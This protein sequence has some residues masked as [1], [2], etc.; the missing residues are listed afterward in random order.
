MAGTRI[1]FISVGTRAKVA[2]GNMTPGTPAGARA[3]DVYICINVQRDNVAASMAATWGALYALNNGTTTRAHAW[4][5]RR[6]TS[7]PD[8]TITRAAGNTGIACVLCFRNCWGEES[9]E[10]PISTTQTQVVSPTSDL[11]VC[12]SAT[13]PVGNDP[14]C[15]NMC[16]FIGHCA[17]NGT[18]DFGAD[19]TNPVPLQVLDD[20][21]ALGLDAGLVVSVGIHNDASATGAR[22]IDYSLSALHI[23]GTILLRAKDQSPQMAQFGV[24]L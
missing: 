23:G 13:P 24:G 22:T 16:I 19:G 9:G 20:N 17:D 2:S 8:F 11:I 3:G 21:T 10:S 18:V 12:P 1:H 15:N 7:E 14:R 5:H 6:G 4:R